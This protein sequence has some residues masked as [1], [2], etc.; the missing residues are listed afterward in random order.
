[1]NYSNR[2]SINIRFNTRKYKHKKNYC[3]VTAS[4]AGSSTGLEELS[5]TTSLIL[6]FYYI[7]LV[8]V[9]TNYDFLASDTVYLSKVRVNRLFFKYT[10]DND[11][12][13][14]I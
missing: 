8:E 5:A 11:H 3:S 4:G 9:E 2:K 12:K 14:D 13:Y 1:L 6:N 7:L 10:I